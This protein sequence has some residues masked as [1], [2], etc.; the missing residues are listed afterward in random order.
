MIY[1]TL[2][3]EQFQQDAAYTLHA[4]RRTRP[5]EIVQ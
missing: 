3:A 2:G 5:V 1:V 4:T